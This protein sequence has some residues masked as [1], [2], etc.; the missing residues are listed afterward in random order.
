MDLFYISACRG[1]A[2]YL[3]NFSDGLYLHTR[4]AKRQPYVIYMLKYRITP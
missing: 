3:E 2:Q 1:G 4:A